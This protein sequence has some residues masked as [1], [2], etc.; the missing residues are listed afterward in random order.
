[1]FLKVASVVAVTEEIF[2]RQSFRDNFVPQHVR[3]ATWHW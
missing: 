1:M 2:F 3:E